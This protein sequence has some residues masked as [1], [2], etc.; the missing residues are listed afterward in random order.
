MSRSKETKI[1]SH[2]RVLRKLSN[3]VK[4]RLQRQE[5]REDVGSLGPSAF[6][7]LHPDDEAGKL[8]PEAVARHD[9]DRGGG[10]R[11]EHQ[12]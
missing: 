2:P 7:F 4:S 6:V 8:A 12:R 3:V 10:N 9:V 5:L 1:N 11:S